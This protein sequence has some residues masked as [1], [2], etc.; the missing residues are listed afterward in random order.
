MIGARE[1]A[2]EEKEKIAGGP[3]QPLSPPPPKS[4]LEDLDFGL[5][6]KG[7]GLP[8]V[9]GGLEFEPSG[10]LSDLM[11]SVAGLESGMGVGVGGGKEEEGELDGVVFNDDDGVERALSLEGVPHFGVEESQKGGEEEDF[12]S[13]FD[14]LDSAE[15]DL[16]DLTD[17]L[18]ALENFKF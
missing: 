4:S 6:G 9:P 7:E 17:A 10:E 11:A 15:A 13:V 8:G 2:R 1:Y 5:L 16:G 12:G 14:N 18:S 3:S